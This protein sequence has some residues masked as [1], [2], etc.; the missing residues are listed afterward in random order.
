MRRIFTI[1]VVLVSATASMWA[2]GGR[3]QVQETEAPEPVDVVILD[4]PLQWRTVSDYFAERGEV[5]SE[6]N[7]APQLAELVAR[8]DLPPVD[9]RLP[10]DP[11]V[12]RATQA[13]G[14]YGGDFRRAWLGPSD[15][16][17]IRHNL[18][19]IPVYL[20]VNGEPQPNLFKD[21][22]IIDDGRVYIFQ[23]REGLRWDDGELMTAHDA[24]F[25]WEIKLDDRLYHPHRDEYL[26]GGE[27][28]IV[29]VIDTYTW[30]ITFPSPNPLFLHA[31]A[32]EGRADLVAPRHYLEQFH[33]DY[34]SEAQME[35]TL[36]ARGFDDWQ[37]LFDSEYQIVRN[38]NRPHWFA[39]RAVT[40]PADS[41][42]VWE[43]NPY[44]FKVDEEGNQLPYL[45]TYRNVMVSEREL[46]LT[47]A[48]GGEISQSWHIGVDN[49]AVLM[50][51]RRQGDYE[52][53]PRVNPDIASVPFISINQTHRDPVIRDVFQD[54][55][56]RQAL[57]LGIDRE[58]I[59][60]IVH[61]GL[62]TPRQMAWTKESVFYDQE[63][64][65]AFT[66]HDVNRA[67]NLL[68]EMGL[69]RGANGYRRYPDGRTLRFA[70]EDPDG[71]NTAT[72]ELLERQ[73][74]Q[75]GIIL[76]INTPER[77][78]FEERTMSN[79]FDMVVW[80]GDRAWN[81][82]LRPVYWAPS[83]RG[84]NANYWGIEWNRYLA[85]NGR[86]GEE[87]PVDVMR[88]NELLGAARETI[89]SGE[90]ARH[91]A[92]IAQWHRDNLVMIGIVG[93]LPEPMIIRNQLMNAH[94]F[95]GDGMYMLDGDDPFLP[96]LWWND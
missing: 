96:T 37:A 4:V 65:N 17:S 12:M 49:W 55:R 90:R 79:N 30:S 2:G 88:L 11:P 46:I 71:R 3:E 52:V 44:Y 9:E 91:M 60:E 48:L 58:E 86:D 56:F 94:V 41:E 1:F 10:V 34:V 15:Q 20:D 31:I 89:D 69:E 13:V 51:N 63:W 72:L 54:V 62:G 19:E 87:P 33:A 82:H 16:W 50:E 22:T 84:A 7:E 39:F 25:W 64:E 53:Y 24:D 92:Q 14:R 36:A 95:S 29:E 23:M 28:P 43:R 74:D 75:I 68:D 61:F 5:F 45:D 70:I 67:N 78:L 38:P 18:R 80:H 85:T 77:T 6:F 57:S 32:R 42:Y 27:K 81:P 83:V 21:F 93:E 59:N 35:Q 40:D 66:E 8:G 76:D 73:W 26:V 47:L